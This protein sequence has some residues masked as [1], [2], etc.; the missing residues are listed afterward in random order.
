MHPF[1]SRTA[2]L[3]AGVVSTVVLAGCSAADNAMPGMDHNATPVAS[4]PVNP[5]ASGAPRSACQDLGIGCPSAT[6]YQDR[7]PSRDF[8]HAMVN[9]DII[10]RVSLDDVR[11]QFAGLSDQR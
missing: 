6:P 11:A 2:L 5:S 9:R 10:R 8:H 7:N 1:I 4:D 3:G